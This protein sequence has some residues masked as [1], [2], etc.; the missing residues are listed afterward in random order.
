MSEPVTII[1]WSAGVAVAGAV[2]AEA[3]VA[4]RARP[5]T[6]E[7]ELIFNAVRVCFFT[8]QSLFWREKPEK[9]DFPFAIPTEAGDPPLDDARGVNQIP[10]IG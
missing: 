3:V 2:C 8:M 7:A 9:P 5:S 1:V 10:H 6:A 4:A